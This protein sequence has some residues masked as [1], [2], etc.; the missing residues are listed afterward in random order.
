MP[1]ACIAAVVL[2]TALLQ[3]PTSAEEDAVARA[4]AAFAKERYSEAA[5]AFGEAYAAQP[6]PR[7][8]WAQAQAER[9]AG[10]CAAAIEIYDAFLATQP[11]EKDATDA[12]KARQ[13][14]QS[15]LER[16]APADTEAEHA[17]TTTTP[18]TEGSATTP[19]DPPKPMPSERP[20]LRWYRDPWG[21]ALVGS[22]VF[23]GGIGIGLLVSAVRLDRDA[24]DAST[25]G[26]YEASRE[27]AVLR[28][29]VGIATVAVGSG[30]VV[31]GVVRWALVGTRGRR[32]RTAFVPA[33]MG[34]AVVGRF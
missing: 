23:V 30:L 5:D 16:A 13:A 10:D 14:C 21:G 25:E 15:E 27:D 8:L 29:R 6:L 2:A 17:A 11:A 26:A 34:M 4:E 18:S 9:L 1:T 20:P 32:S 31:A 12:R 19:A 22:G 7:Y 28:Q 24:G 33:P 3:E